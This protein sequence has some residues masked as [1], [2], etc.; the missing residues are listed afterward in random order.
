MLRHAPVGM[1]PSKLRPT[2]GFLV[3][4]LLRLILAMS[5]PPGPAHAQA[6]FK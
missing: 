1:A 6:A 4:E 3:I 2:H 5:A